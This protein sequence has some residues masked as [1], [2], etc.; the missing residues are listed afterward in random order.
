M[1]NWATSQENV[2]FKIQINNKRM[3]MEQTNRNIQENW[4]QIRN[5][6]DD[7]LEM[8]FSTHTKTVNSIFDNK[9]LWE[10]TDR[11]EFGL[12]IVLNSGASEHVVNKVA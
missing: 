3:L 8:N 1:T 7:Y 12:N 6:H 10:G 11:L 9:R 4:R 2:D 5:K